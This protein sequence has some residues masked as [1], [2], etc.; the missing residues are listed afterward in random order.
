MDET[1]PTMAAV[2]KGDNEEFHLTGQELRLIRNFRA[3][4]AGARD[5]LVDLSEQYKRTLPAEAPSLQL[6]RSTGR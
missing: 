5:M 3:L 4:K 6:V 1:V 2:P